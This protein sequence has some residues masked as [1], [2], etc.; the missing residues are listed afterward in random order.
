MKFS[1]II[2]VILSKNNEKKL[3]YWKT[4][5]LIT[6]CL[7]L[8]IVTIT[9]LIFTVKCEVWNVSSKIGYII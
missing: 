7:K 5:G 1:L 2:K 6:L 4:Y 8:K 3:K 9:A